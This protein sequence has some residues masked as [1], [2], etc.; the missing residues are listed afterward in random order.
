[1]NLGPFLPLILSAFCAINATAQDEVRYNTAAE[2]YLQVELNAPMA[3]DAFFQSLRD[4]WREDIRISREPGQNHDIEDL[5][6]SQMEAVLL[7][8]ERYLEAA[9]AAYDAQLDYA[10]HS[11]SIVENESP[12]L[13]ATTL[14]RYRRALQ[15]L[16]MQDLQIIRKA[17]PLVA[18]PPSC[19]VV[20][21]DAFISAINHRAEI[22]VWGGA[23]YRQ[24][25]SNAGDFAQQ[26]LE[27]KRKYITAIISRKSD[28]I[29]LVPELLS[30]HFPNRTQPEN[31][32]ATALEKFMAAEEAWKSYSLRAAHLLHPGGLGEGQGS[33][34]CEMYLRIDI[35]KNHEKYYT[36]LLMGFAK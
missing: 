33:G 11:L 17:S 4:S 18:D 27:S 12:E 32:D 3:D 26:Q 2:R 20:E 35:M 22:S 31:H 15:H 16:Y 24:F 9:R 14:T 19:N 34:I 23:A 1:M 10:R 21:T 29:Y 8:V 6:A 13:Y 30:N 25:S 28:D 7:T 36:L 5:S